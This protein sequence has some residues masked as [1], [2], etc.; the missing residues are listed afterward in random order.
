MADHELLPVLTGS[1][2]TVVTLAGI[3]SGIINDVTTLVGFIAIP[4]IGFGLTL[5]NY[6]KHSAD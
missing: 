6:L 5:A 4:I 2:V 1:F 3:A